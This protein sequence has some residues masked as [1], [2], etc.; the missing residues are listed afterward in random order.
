MSE[1]QAIRLIHA[2]SNDHR[3]IIF[4]RYFDTVN[5]CILGI[6]GDDC[7]YR[8]DKLQATLDTT[9][10]K[11]DSVTRHDT[12]NLQEALAKAMEIREGDPALWQAIL[13]ERARVRKQREE[14]AAS[15]EG[16]AMKHYDNNTIGAGYV[17]NT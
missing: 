5:G 6:K 1:V 8:Y 13:E 11:P 17:I 15:S 9:L 4:N 16:Q 14:S 10:H 7:L 3:L 12:D 2:R